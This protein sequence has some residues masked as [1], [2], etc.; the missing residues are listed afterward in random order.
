MA[1]QILYLQRICNGICNRSM[2]YIPTT[3][4]HLVAVA[5]KNH[6]YNLWEEEKNM[7]IFAA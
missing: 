7:V 4:K 5:D 6:F 1:L 2:C 3:Y